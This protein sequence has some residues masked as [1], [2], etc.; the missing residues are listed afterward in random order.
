[1]PSPPSSAAKSFYVWM[2]KDFKD[3]GLGIGGFMD[4]TVPYILELWREVKIPTG[5]MG[6]VILSLP[7]IAM[8]LVFLQS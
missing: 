4:E 7:S 3:L 2:R 5:T 6:G 8:T 1:M